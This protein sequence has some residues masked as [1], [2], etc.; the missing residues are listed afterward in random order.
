MSQALRTHNATLREV[1]A[2]HD[3]YEVK[4]IGDAFMLAFARAVDAITF[5]V[6]A[7][8]RLVESEWPGSLC[9][10]LSPSQSGSSIGIV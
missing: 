4:V 1:A 7:Q 3:G 6:E 9:G 5:G 8:Q 10:E 2:A